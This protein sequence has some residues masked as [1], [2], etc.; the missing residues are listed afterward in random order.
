M[1]KDSKK[2]EDS[3]VNGAKTVET[4]CLTCNGSK[5]TKEKINSIIDERRKA[6]GK[7]VNK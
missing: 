5:L 1:V 4:P 2:V 7:I 6:A 3:E